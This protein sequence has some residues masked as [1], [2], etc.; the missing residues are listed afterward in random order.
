MAQSVLR[1]L[2]VKEK[3]AHNSA[4]LTSTKARRAILRL[5]LNKNEARFLKLFK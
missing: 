2:S 1:V 3:K 4:V 5:S